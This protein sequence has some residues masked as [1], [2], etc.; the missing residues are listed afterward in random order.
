MLLQC[1]A[2]RCSRQN[3]F[4]IKSITKKK[5]YGCYSSLHQARGYQI[6]YDFKQGIMSVGR[7]NF[8]K[9]LS[10]GSGATN[11][12]YKIKKARHVTLSWL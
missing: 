10:V 11:K 3:V 12:I 6:Y 9:I 7:V 8:E 5:T 2:V 4:M 1:H